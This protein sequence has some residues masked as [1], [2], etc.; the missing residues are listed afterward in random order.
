VTG[1][2]FGPYPGRVIEVHDGD[3]LTLDLDLG[4]GVRLPGQSWGGKT[5]LACRVHGINSPELNT[6]A[7]KAARA[8]ASGLLPPGTLVTVTSYG[9]DKYG[10]RFLGGITLGDGR[11]FATLM[12]DAGQA[13]PY[14]GTG[15]KP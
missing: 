10:G 6:D 1:A 15:P 8:Y 3:T 12:L 14:S 2:V 9:W 5:L 4:F 7:G 13:R 11:D